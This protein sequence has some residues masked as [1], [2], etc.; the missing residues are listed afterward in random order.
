MKEKEQGR[1]I[2]GLEEFQQELRYGK[3]CSFKSLAKTANDKQSI[4]L[5]FWKWPTRV[6]TFQDTRTFQLSCR[7][8]SETIFGILGRCWAVTASQRKTDGGWR[9][10]L[11]GDA[12]LQ[13]P[14][15]FTGT[16]V[17]PRWCTSWARWSH[18]TWPTT[19]RG[20]RWKVTPHLPTCTSCTRTT[21]SCGGSST[22][23]TWC[24]RC[25][26]R[27][28]TPLSTAAS[29]RRARRQV[30]ISPPRDLKRL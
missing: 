9:P 29:L 28:G 3:Y 25:S 6:H 19:L 1:I 8:F 17:T 2:L 11:L 7:T 10:F 27:M 18:G 21:C 4:Y 13:P 16:A 26:G 12:C 30:A 14:L 5:H 22:P 15:V 23:N 20:V 24:R